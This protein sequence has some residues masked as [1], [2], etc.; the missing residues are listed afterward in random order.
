MLLDKTKVACENEHGC[1]DKT[2]SLHTSG[3]LRFKFCNAY[4]P[5][6]PNRLRLC[7]IS[8]QAPFCRRGN[9]KVAA[10]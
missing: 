8:E 1:T 3:L 5:C 2:E 6:L 9:C 10:C 7:R 4:Y